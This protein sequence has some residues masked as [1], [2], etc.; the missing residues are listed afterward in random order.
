[1]RPVDQLDADSE[2]LTLFTNDKTDARQ[3]HAD[4]QEYEITIDRSL[5]KKAK[6]VLEHGMLIDG[7]YCGGVRIV[8]TLNKGRRTI[9]TI[10]VAEERSRD[11]R[12]MFD[13][14]GYHV[15][16]IKRTRIGAIKLGTLPVGKWRFFDEKEM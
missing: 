6:D 7:T 2:G 11:I 16:S 1:M 14:L 12:T 15:I 4:V 13:R 10:Q 5:E 8:R 3:F 9:A